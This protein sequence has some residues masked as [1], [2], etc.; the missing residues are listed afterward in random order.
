[1]NHDARAVLFLGIVTLLPFAWAAVS[2]ARSPYSVFQSILYF[3]SLLFSRLLWR[4]NVPDPLPLEPGRGVLIVSNHRSSIDPFFVQLAAGR[5]VHWLVARE[6]CESRWFGWFL[7]ACE[8]IP[9]NR[10]GIDTAATK[11]SI[12]R[13][14]AGDAVGM[15][16][17]GRINM[18]ERLLLP[19]R[20][21]I[22]LVAL[23]ARVPILPCYIDGSPYR[24]TPWSPFF[25]PARVRVRFGPLIDLTPWHDRNE[26]GLTEQIT[27]RCLREIA[28]L[29]GEPDFEPQIASR[30]WKPTAAEVAEG[31]AA[32]EKRWSGS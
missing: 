14:G 19:G 4:S 3:L 23:R 9:V 31:T 28:R 26:D 25:M 10:G 8:A 15:F 32:L 27:L 24:G 18:T 6:Y 12:R 17:E 22:A 1:M 2:L 20:P 13:C 30:N 5:V 16:P 29:G 11:A 21:G 7:R